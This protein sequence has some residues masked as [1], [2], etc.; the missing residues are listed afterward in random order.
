GAVGSYIHAGGRIG[1]LIEINCET[2]FVA[3]TADFQTLLKDLAMHIAASEPRF[4]GRDEVTEA[5]LRDE[6]EIYRTQARATGKP[7]AVVEK[8]VQGKMEKFYQEFCLLEQPFVR[9]PNLSVQEMLNG[10]IAKVG[11]N[12]RV[13]RFTRYVLG[14]DEARRGEAATSR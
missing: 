5:I 14:Q 12:I 4:I 1:V 2:D 7:D 11:E 3:R 9:D 8:I 6:K 10:I 13:K